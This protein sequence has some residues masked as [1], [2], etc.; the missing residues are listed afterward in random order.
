TPR[1]PR[2][3][4]VPRV[5]RVPPEPL[6]ARP[7]ACPAARVPAARAAELADA[8]ADRRTAPAATHHPDRRLTRAVQGCSRTGSQLPPARDGGLGAHRDPP[9]QVVR[10]EIIR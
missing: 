4:R 3:P 7:Y 9:C 2:A 1:A 5:P 10:G 8:A 6:P